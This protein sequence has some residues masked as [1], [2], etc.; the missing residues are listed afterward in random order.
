M[1]KNYNDFVETLLTAG[2]SFSTSN[3]DGI[4]AVVPWGW[5]ET[6]PYDTPVRWHTGCPETDP[7]EWRTR[8]L[9]ERDD[10]A[11]GKLFLKRSGFITREWYPYFLAAR[12]G[13]DTFQDAYASGTLS[14]AAKRIYDTITS[15]GILPSHDLKRLGGFTKKEKSAFERGLVELQMKM[16][17]TVCGAQQKISQKG[18]AYGMSSSMFC[19]TEKFWGRDVFD[20]AE[21]MSVDEAYDAVREQVL[22]LNPLA[23]EKK[24]VKFILGK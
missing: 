24:I 22:K 20:Q 14:H 15:N 21:E 9:Y 12:R 17:I 11:Y 4:Y 13:S 8:V 6:P 16:F 1:I 3:A 18:D 2:F 19:T 10:I 23:E 7:W 5:N